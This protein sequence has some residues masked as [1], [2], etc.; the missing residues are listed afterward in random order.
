LAAVVVVVAE[1]KI[2][3]LAKELAGLAER[4]T[5]MLMV[6]VAWVALRAVA[7]VLLGD[8]HPHVLAEAA[9]VE[10][11]MPQVLE[12]LVVLR[13]SPA[14]LGPVEGAVKMLAV[15]VQSVVVAKYEC[16]RYE[17]RSSQ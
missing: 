3:V 9:V 17:I 10:A 6:G 4:T 13:A 12:A 8:P 5:P 11:E 2:P 16:G 1:G 15:W 14:G 7:L